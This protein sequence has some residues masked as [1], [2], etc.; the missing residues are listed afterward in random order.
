MK[1]GLQLGNVD[2]A[3]N[4]ELTHALEVWLDEEQIPWVDAYPAMQAGAT[5]YYW[6]QDYHL[7]VAGHDLVARE[8]LA[9]LGPRLAAATASR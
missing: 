1:T 3:V 9:K 7:N 5:E 8:I 6:M 4:R 2:L